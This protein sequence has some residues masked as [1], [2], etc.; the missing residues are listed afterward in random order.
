MNEVKFTVFQMGQYLWQNHTQEGNRLWDQ[1]D[2]V[3]I[4]TLQLNI[5]TSNTFS[6][7]LNLSY[8][9][10]KGNKKSFS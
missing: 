9:L 1:K 3:S 5:V 2:L 10:E 7:S 4:S 8:H 6:S